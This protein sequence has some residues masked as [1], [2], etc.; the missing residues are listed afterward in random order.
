[1]HDQLHSFPE[2]TVL[3]GAAAMSYRQCGAATGTTVL[4]LHG[5]GSGAA[6]WLACASALAPD[7]RVIA[8]NA[9]GY[10]N[11]APLEQTRPVAADYAARLHQMVDALGL[12]KFVLVGHSLGALV[13]AAY[14]AAHPER[15]EKLVLLSPAQGYGTDQKR[16]RGA[17]IRQ[18]RLHDLETIGIDGM[19]ARSPARMLS[20]E[21]SA[22]ARDWVRWNTAQLQPA[23]YTQAVELLCGDAIGNYAF[24]GVPAAVF[25]GSED[26]VTTPHDSAALAGRLDLPYENIAAAGH[27][28]YIEQ[29]ERVAAAI[30]QPI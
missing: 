26:I 22:A 25:C 20:P 28:C 19:A 1:M 10:G 17:T 29:P 13:A 2:H 27:A 14:A 15:L 30:R 23:G 16:E 5:I 18:T 21:A 9:P 7:A 3:D 11:S 8:W 4:L 24:D 6:S 12:D